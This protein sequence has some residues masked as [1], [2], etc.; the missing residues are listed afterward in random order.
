MRFEQAEDE[1]R[2]RHKNRAK[3]LTELTIRSK[4]HWNYDER[5]IE[6]W[7]EDLTN[8]EEYAAQKADIYRQSKSTYSR[9]AH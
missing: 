5:E 6:A 8:T 2:D 1:N 4:S 3:D 9:S 7:R